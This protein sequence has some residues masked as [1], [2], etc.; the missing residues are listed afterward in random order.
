MAQAK[1]QEHDHHD[2]MMRETAREV[3]Q[4]HEAPAPIS[5]PETPDFFPPLV[6]NGLGWGALIGG[7]IGFIFGVLLYN[8]ILVIA[9]W[10]GLYSMEVGAFVILWLFLGVAAGVVVGG[11]GAILAATP[12]MLPELDED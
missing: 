2:S 5:E 12:V 6:M 9:G 11:I 7:T 10:E 1:Q 8:N 4:F 3:V